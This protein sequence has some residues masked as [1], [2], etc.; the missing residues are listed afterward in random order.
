MHRLTVYTYIIY[1]YT[2]TG[3]R[4][5]EVAGSRHKNTTRG[6]AGFR[7]AGKIISRDR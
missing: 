7:S 2:G 1:I 3:E 6:K 5:L 4:G